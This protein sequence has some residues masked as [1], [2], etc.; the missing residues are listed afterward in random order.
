MVDYCILRH[1]TCGAGVSQQSISNCTTPPTEV[2][3]KG[4]SRNNFRLE[5]IGH[6]TGEPAF[7]KAHLSHPTV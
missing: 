3:T 2:G 7:A 1:S 5:S 6:A 4:K